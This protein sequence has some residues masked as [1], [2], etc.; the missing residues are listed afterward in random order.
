MV[1]SQSDGA[2]IL[3]GMRFA[4]LF[5]ATTATLSSSHFI[6]SIGIVLLYV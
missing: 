6:G 1:N 5:L 2:T 3:P 4:G